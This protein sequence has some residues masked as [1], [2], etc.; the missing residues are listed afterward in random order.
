MTEQMLRKGATWDTFLE[1]L[2]QD[3]AGSRALSV[4]AH[5]ALILPLLLISPR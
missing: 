2:M 4:D 3:I 1:P 5:P